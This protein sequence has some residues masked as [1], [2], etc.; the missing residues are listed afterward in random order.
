MR[1]QKL[2]ALTLVVFFSIIMLSINAQDFG[3]T[4]TPPSNADQFGFLVGDWEIVSERNL[5]AFDQSADDETE[6]VWEETVA[7]ANTSLH[8]DGNAYLQ[9]WVGTLGDE[10][11]EATFFY[12]IRSNNQIWD[13]VWADSHLL[14]IHLMQGSFDDNGTFTSDGAIWQSD[15]AR[16]VIDN[17]TQDSFTWTMSLTEGIFS[18]DFEDVWI[19]T[20]SR[21]IEDSESAYDD[22]AES[23][24]ASAT[25]SS[26]PEGI[27]GFSF[28][29]GEWDIQSMYPINDMEPLPARSSIQW[30]NGGHAFEEHWIALW[31]MDEAV[32]PFE[33]FSLSIFNTTT[34]TFNNVWWQI[35]SRGAQRFNSGICTGEGE[36]YQCR[37]AGTFYNITGDTI[38]WY[39]GNAVNPS[40][41][42]EFNRRDVEEN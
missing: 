30:V 11:V 9:H 32:A 8:L 19:M 28:W 35:N 13:I 38:D 23:I 12:G 1:Q 42:L 37:L 33:A 6:A 20:F 10:L 3:H 34:N 29:I 22:L 2:L 14:G 16:I 15:S 18:T 31:G 7:V 26:P 40:W 17:V 27:T 39:I 25:L 36:D 24:R 5:T 21:I 41:A 4:G